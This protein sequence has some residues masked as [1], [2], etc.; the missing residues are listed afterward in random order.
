[1]RKL[2]EDD[3][4]A[5]DLLLDQGLS[6]DAD[7]S[8]RTGLTPAPA[9]TFRQRLRAAGRVLNVLSSLPA[10]EPPIDLVARTLRRIERADAQGIRT[11]DLSF[12]ERPGQ[13]VTQANQPMA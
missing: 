13:D 8:G 3:G 6:V 10:G 2:R 11:A 9:D 12:V 4:R 5:V 1:M 7:G